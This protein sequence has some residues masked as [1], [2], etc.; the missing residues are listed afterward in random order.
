MNTSKKAA[1]KLDWED[2]RRRLAVAI[3]EERLSASADRAVLEARAARHALQGDPEV[4]EARLEIL[5]FA[6][7][8]R[9]FAIES[10]YVAEVARLGHLSRV[11]GAR[12]GLLG[13]C[14][15]R[16]DLLPVFDLVSVASSANAAHLVVLGES[17]PDFGI[18]VDALE[19]V[20]SVPE[21]S[22]SAARS[23]GSLP[24]PE[25]VRG[26]SAEGLLVLDGAAL[27]RDR[28]VFVASSAVHGTLEQELT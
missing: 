22:L 6:R 17:A 3:D 1:R 14:N 19:A 13:L 24:H 15:L 25:H 7:G 28:T 27:L 8:G 21:A 10:R 20:Q 4:S 2:V 9:R 26:V 11:P 5:V 16:G 12:P 18:A 23:V